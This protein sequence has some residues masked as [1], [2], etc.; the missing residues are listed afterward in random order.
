MSSQCSACI[1]AKR[2]TIRLMHG[3]PAGLIAL[4]LSLCSIYTSLSISLYLTL[5]ISLSLCL[6]LANDSKLKSAWLQ[7]FFSKVTQIER[8]NLSKGFLTKI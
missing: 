5:S 6:S 7:S 4:C 2:T 3:E 1:L 8:K